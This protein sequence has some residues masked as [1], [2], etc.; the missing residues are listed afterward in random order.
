MN[1]FIIIF[2]VMTQPLFPQEIISVKQIAQLTGQ[3][4]VNNGGQVNV[5]GTDLGSMFLHSDGKIYLLFGDTFGQPGTGN[6]RS[7]TMAYTTDFVASDG[8]AFDGWITDP[9]GQA[10]A[11]VEGNHNPNDGSGEVTKIPTA[12][13]SF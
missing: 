8:I 3:P 11:L 2:L 1:R 6:W 9:S 7:N 12:G 5:Y 13:W 10:K 4:S